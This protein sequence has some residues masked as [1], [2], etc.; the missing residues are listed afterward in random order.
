MSQRLAQLSNQS[1]AFPP[2]EQ[3]LKEPNGL[4][5]I[6]GDLS[7]QR[8][9]AAYQHGIFPWYS[10][11][12]PLLWWSPDP[13]AIINIAQ[14]KINRSLAKFLRKS[15]FTVTL[16][17]DFNQVLRYCS[18]APFRKEDTWILPD[19]QLAYQKLHHLGLAHSIEVWHQQELV[20]GLYGVAINGFFSGESMFYKQSNASKVALVYLANHLK[21]AGINFIDCQLIN[22]FLESMG[23][24]EITRK[25]FVKLKDKAL[26][27]SLENSFWQSQHLQFNYGK[28]D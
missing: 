17:H 22:P 3:A 19:M 23:A 21:S 13:R 18:N 25:N 6:G 7:A 5:A 15:P 4:L 1:L 26:T 12:D 27:I 8:L 11:H 16:N 2:L 10:E 9:A 28:D 14:L 20:G 24:I